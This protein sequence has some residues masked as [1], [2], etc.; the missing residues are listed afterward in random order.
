[1]IQSKQATPAYST[2]AYWAAEPDV[3]RYA[4]F[5]SD[6]ISRYY[7]DCEA[8]GRIEIWKRI[9]ELSFGRCPDSDR[10][11]LGLLF[12]GEA[13]ETT[14]V[15]VNDFR[16]LLDTVYAITTQTRPAFEAR[17]DNG[18]SRTLAQRQI[19]DAIIAHHLNEPGGMEAAAKQAARFAIHMTE[20][21][22]FAWW[23]MNAGDVYGVE[24]YLEPEDEQKVAEYEQAKG[25]YDQQAA[26]LMDTSVPA[27]DNGGGASLPEPPPE[28]E[29]TWLER[30]RY[31]GA[32]RFLAIPPEDLIRDPDLESI[33]WSW[34]MVRRQAN[35]WDL[36]TQFPEHAEHIRCATKD[37][38]S[39]IGLRRERSRADSTDQIE[40]FEMFH[41]PT[42]ALPRGRWSI[43]VDDRVV[44]D[45][46]MPYRRL[47]VHSMVPGHE[48]Q[49]PY[50]YGASMDLLGL[51][52]ARDSIFSIMLSNVE[53]LGLARLWTP[54]G[55]TPDSF[56]MEHGLVNVQSAEK[57]EVLDLVPNN[58][59]PEKL[60][61]IDGRSMEQLSGVNQTTR[62]QPPPESKSGVSHAFLHSM[63]IQNNAP[64]Q[65]AWQ[66]VLQSLAAGTIE[67]YQDFAETPR[68]ISIAGKGK[69][70]QAVQFTN[71]KIDRVRNVSVDLGNPMMRV[72]AGRVT[73]ADQYLQLKLIGPQEHMEL[74]ETG[75]LESITEAAEA[76]ALLIAAE[77]EKLRS[78][79]DEEG[80]PV[81][82]LVSKYDQHHLHIPEHNAI[83]AD[84]M[85]RY[86]QE[87]TRRIFETNELHRYWWN[88]LSRFEP[89]M[90]Q[91]HGI[92]IIP[93]PTM[94]IMP[95]KQLAA[96]NMPPI[97]PLPPM[98]MP[99]APP[100]GPGAP[101]G[102]PPPRPKGDGPPKPANDNGAPE[103]G[104]GM[105]G[106]PKGAQVPPEVAAQATNPGMTI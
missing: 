43:L 37:R 39:R 88:Y 86:D 76:F 83:L 84:P 54:Y 36:A 74:I 71:K 21:Y 89:D 99:G 57:P 92:P 100:G 50:G 104:P 48:F 4:A 102:G 32:P 23:D 72:L 40:I 20:G 106:L 73:I 68:I 18:D 85:I 42:S 60:F 41:K 56:T 82:V 97:L 2:E 25:E 44:Y 28:P 15:R 58:D 7:S 70:Y 34:V 30:L 52:Q 93:P 33:D 95:P 64:V 91:A 80:E 90:A 65:D 31:Q 61:E 5:L 17:A 1:V 98:P 75:R 27:N 62:G 63:S 24:P 8:S 47:P 103:A 29:V 35:R 78:G 13:G 46:M 67:L 14:E 66:R 49:E 101:A 55:P 9:R 81:E 16:A 79:V 45:G 6:R 105:P 10:T 77:N 22:V 53:A 11:S 38:K 19:A 94:P 51:Q 59:V 96:M 69:S 87:V 26:M 12:G 3:E